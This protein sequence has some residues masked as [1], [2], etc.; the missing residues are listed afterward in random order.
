MEQPLQ[1]FVRRFGRKKLGTDRRRERG[2]RRRRKGIGK[3]D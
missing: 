3:G 2:K 1:D